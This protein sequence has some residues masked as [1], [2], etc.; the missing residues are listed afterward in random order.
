MKF[1]I[2]QNVCF[3]N[4]GYFSWVICCS[5]KSNALTNGA[6]IVFLTKNAISVAFK[7]NRTFYTNKDVDPSTE[8][9]VKYLR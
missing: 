7:N 3:G 9:Q 5:N 1:N 4:I 8:L 6:Q 2:I